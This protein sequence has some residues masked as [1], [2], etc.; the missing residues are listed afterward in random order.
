MQWTHHSPAMCKMLIGA[1]L[2]Y[3][4]LKNLDMQKEKVD[5]DEVS[6]CCC[7]CFVYVY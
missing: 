1:D 3:Y 5:F 7:M 4:L 2:V 6:F